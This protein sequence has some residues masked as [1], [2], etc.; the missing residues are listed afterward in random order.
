M[1]T[2]GEA[3]GA[4]VLPCCGA[5][6]GRIVR[7]SARARDPEPC[8]AFQLSRHVR[9]RAA[10]L[11]LEGL[12]ARAHRFQRQQ[13]SAATAATP[14]ALGGWDRAC[15]QQAATSLAASG[16]T[17]EA[18]A[19]PCSEV[20]TAPCPL[21]LAG[22]F[23]SQP[24]GPCADAPASVYRGPEPPSWPWAAKRQPPTADQG[25]GGWLNQPNSSPLGSRQVQGGSL[26]NG[27]GSCIVRS[28]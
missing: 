8:S 14:A 28:G 4:A 15:R 7:R 2:A 23:A 1:A 21:L 27:P 17:I 3:Q 13:S 12:G 11:G 5:E 10:C 20:P 6:W 19:R 18:A 26:G 25:G 9:H 24:H 16:L 22:C